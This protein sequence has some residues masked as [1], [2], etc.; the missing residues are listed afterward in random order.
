L[1]QTQLTNE[2][3]EYS[4]VVSNNTYHLV[5]D[6]QSLSVNSGTVAITA[7]D[8]LVT[9]NA[10]TSKNLELYVAIPPLNTS[11]CSYVGSMGGREYWRSNWATY[12]Q[13]MQDDFSNR[14]GHL[15][16]LS[17]EAESNFINQ[18]IQQV[19]G[20]FHLGYR[21]NG[22]TWYWVDGSPFGFTNWAPSEPSG[23]SEVSHVFLSGNGHVYW[24]DVWY[25][26]PWLCGIMES[27]GW[28]RPYVPKPITLLSV[29]PQRDFT[30]N[31][32]WVNP[33]EVVSGLD[34]NPG[35]QTIIKRNGTIVHT[36]DNC[37]P[38][39][40]MNWL[41]SLPIGQATYEI[42]AQN[43][44][45]V[46]EIVTYD[47][48]FGNATLSGSVVS[49]YGGYPLSD[50][51]VKLYNESKTELLQTATTNTIGE[52]S[53]SNLSYLNYCVVVE[54]QTASING[55][56]ITF[57]VHEQ[58]VEVR[59][60][61]NTLV[62]LDVYASEVN[63]DNCTYIG[64]LNGHDYW[65]SNWANY[66]IYMRDDFANRGGYLVSINS[67][68]ESQFI[69]QYITQHPTNYLLGL[70]W[71]GTS[72][73]WMDGS[74][75]TYTNWA[76][77]QPY[78]YVYCLLNSSGFWNSVYYWNISEFGIMESYG[79]ETKLKPKPI[80]GLSVQQQR[81][82]TI[83]LS[84][85]NPSEVLCGL[86]LNNGFDIVIKRDGVVVATL[87]NCN[88]GEV[89]NWQEFVLTGQHTYVIYVQNEIGQ[90]IAVSQSVQYGNQVQGVARL[91]NTSDHSGIKVKFF[92]DPTTPAAV[93]DSTYTNA[94]GFYSI[95]LTIGR[96]TVVYSKAGY[97]DQTYNNY[98]HSQP[99][100]L[101]EQTLEYVGQIM[102][103]SGSLSGTITAEYAYIINS[104]IWVDSGNTLT[105]EQG[106]R[107]YFKNGIGFDVNGTLTAIGT[108]QNPI[109]FTSVT[110]ETR[111]EFWLNAHG[112]QLEHCEFTKGAWALRL[113][114]NSHVSHSKF[115]GNNIGIGI[116]DSAGDGCLFDY[117]EI[118]GN[119][120]HAILLYCYGAVL[121]HNDI[122][123][124]NVGGHILHKGYERAAT[125]TY[126]YIHNNHSNSYMIY[127]Y[128]YN[129]FNFSNNRVENNSSNEWLY[130][131]EYGV[132]VTFNN[133][134][135]QNNQC[136]NLIVFRGNNGSIL[137]NMISNNTGSVQI[138][139]GGQSVIGNT[140]LHNTW[141]GLAV[142]GGNQLIKQNTVVGNNGVGMDVYD[143]PTIRNNVVAFNGG[144]ELVNNSGNNSLYYNLFY[145]AIGNISENPGGL[146]FLMNLQATNANGTPCDSYYNISTNPLF[147]DVQSNNYNLLATSPCINAGDPAS[148]HDPDGTIADLG[149]YYY[150]L[151]AS[152]HPQIAIPL[153]LY[154]FL[155]LPVGETAVWNCPVRNTGTDP[156]IISSIQLN[157]PVF[158]LATETRSI[159]P[160]SLTIPPSQTGYI[161][162]G[163]TPA[164][165]ADYADTLRIN[166]NALMNPQ[167]SIRIFGAG[168]ISSSVTL[169]MPQNNVV[170]V[171]SDFQ[172]PLSIS[173]TTPYNLLSYNMSLSYDPAIFEF[174]GLETSGTLSADW[175]TAVN[176]ISPGVLHIGASGITPLS[177]SGNLFKLNFHTLSGIADGTES[178]ININ[179]VTF[180]EGGLSLQGC[181][182]A[183][184]IRNII[185]GDVDDNLAIQAYDAALTLQYSVMMDPLPLIDPRPWL[186]WRKLRADVSGDGNIYA[187]DAS[188]ILQRV[189]GLISVFPVEQT[190]PEPPTASVELAYY[191]NQLI[192]SSPDFSSLYAL[193]LSFAIPEGMQL[194]SPQLS[195]AFSEAVWN[196]NIAEGAWNFG[197]ACITPPT[198][199]GTVCIIPITVP[200][201]MQIEIALTVN[202]S[203]S[204]TV[205]DLLPTSLNEVPALGMNYLAQNS[206]NPFNP[207]TVITYGVKDAAPVILEIY[208]L[209]GQKVKTL[210]NET[211]A[212]GSYS[213]TWQG[214]DE[215]GSPVGSGVYICRMKLG[216]SWTKTI[217]MM[218]MK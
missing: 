96:Y 37:Q 173:D 144:T 85:T 38:G 180:N 116:M 177:G 189:V 212:S 194:G 110:S 202:E 133:N 107:F 138:Q 117:N 53:F 122:Y 160:F 4:F 22:S 55:Q 147:F 170:N 130:I 95:N 155:A 118:Y 152:T 14:G 183:V 151:N 69:T 213:I 21:Y 185:Y 137:N 91:D 51:T 179:Q 79:Q 140:I 3:G 101:P 112:S 25:W 156:L 49:A 71:N 109:L 63:A 64:G 42:Y 120:E 66:W 203:S 24:D 123:N 142:W 8:S 31:L 80:T 39:Q 12:W 43:T 87:T 134:I 214:N 115:H 67:E 163:F 165:V 150:D 16:T 128:Y 114:S 34:L 68:A 54:L 205:L 164:A 172:L 119:T 6:A 93:T 26:D 98:L 52:F 62:P 35:F 105:L 206:P 193:N 15:V 121:T 208:N 97:L 61:T 100:V 56:N 159:L 48:L 23:N 5:I 70:E 60:D 27:N 11:D 13:Y 1:L 92:A 129:W 153:S 9:V 47:L 175:F 197:L 33:S 192:V 166:S 200:T 209:K 32:S 195:E 94:N 45:G 126:N 76:P 72:W 50:F 182:A 174:V 78:Y 44:Y 186:D 210:V 59:A 141:T 199:S 113:N 131:D 57:S 154:N 218:L 2:L 46:S 146:P 28:Q 103:L 171:L 125:F 82:F 106:V 176:S 7:N 169:A 18:Y 77:G 30:I 73:N 75:M 162:I 143:S 88:V 74:A 99:T 90:S 29:Q 108:S 84:W 198:G 211:K 204:T 19:E 215:H 158:Y 40:A 148:A 41:D 207:S 145:D 58:I 216:N 136:G 104:Q 65:R 111:G 157:N 190:R 102:Y 139:G 184:T 20:D 181:F 201:P 17:S 132:Q 81:D 124:N 135:I 196:Q 89:M 178:F 83:N 36:I 167:V 191:N 161:P 127:L 188:L 10:D 86:T 217:K 149:A 187:Y 168:T